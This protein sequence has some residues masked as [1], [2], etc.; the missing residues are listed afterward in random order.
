MRKIKLEILSLSY[1]QTHSSSFT[2]VLIEPKKNKKLPIIIGSAEAQSIAMQ[3]E[4]MA[5][6][7]PLSHDIIK[8]FADKF[9]I[10]VTEIIIYNLIEGVFFS[11]IICNN[12][13]QEEEID[14]RTSD[15]VAIALRFN[16]PIYTYDFI[17]STAGILLEEDVLDDLQKDEAVTETSEPADAKTDYASYTSEELKHQLNKAIEEEDYERATHLRDEIAK[18][19]NT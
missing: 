6:P 1:S 10:Q 14:S 16:C 11:K 19:K 15:A 13:G 18:R 7:R 5:P 8:S 3:L 17:L 4:K 9:A 12:G 2:L